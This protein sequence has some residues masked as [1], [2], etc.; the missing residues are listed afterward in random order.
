M[1]FQWCMPVKEMLCKRDCYGQQ[2]SNGIQICSASPNIDLKPSKAARLL[3]KCE[4]QTLG[5]AGS[6]EMDRCQG[7]STSWH[8]WESMPPIHQPAN[9]YLLN[10]RKKCDTRSWYLIANQLQLCCILLML[11][12]YV[13]FSTFLQSGSL[14]LLWP[15]L[16]C[17]VVC[18]SLIAS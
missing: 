8:G 17:L 14:L 1:T 5:E 15:L 7:H 3:T 9:Q 18:I 13:L 4:L 10:A 11:I 12:K 2:H 16:F 6:S